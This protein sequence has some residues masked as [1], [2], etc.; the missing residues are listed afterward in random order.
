MVRI[1]L[2]D[3]DIDGIVSVQEVGPGLSQLQQLTKH[4][5][6]KHSMV[7]QH[8]HTYMNLFHLM[9]SFLLALLSALYVCKTLPPLLL[10][11]MHLSSGIAFS[12]HS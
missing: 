5:E 4:I 12:S 8:A 2:T 1:K 11:L 9:F 7:T 10:S 3:V 6:E